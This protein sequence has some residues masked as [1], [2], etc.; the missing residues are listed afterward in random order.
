M[1]KAALKIALVLIF[2]SCG[3]KGKKEKNSQPVSQAKIIAIYT[4]PDGKKVATIAFRVINKNIRYDSTLKNDVIVIDTLW[5]IEKPVPLLDSL[6][7]PI[8]DSLG[9]PRFQLFYVK[10]SKDSINT[11]IENIPLDSLLK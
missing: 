1:K 10:V 5:G 2:I 6:K 4:G 7:Q 3:D 9:N 8:K 11:H